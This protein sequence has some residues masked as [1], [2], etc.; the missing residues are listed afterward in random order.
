MSSAP[1]PLESPDAPVPPRIPPR[2]RYRA[3]WVLPIVAPPIRSGWVDVQDGRV[4]AVGAPG[5]EPDARVDDEIDLGR[6][7]LLPGLVNAH[8]HLELSWLWGRVPPAVSFTAWVGHLIALR[9]AEGDKPDA[10]TLVLTECEE[11]GT[12]LVGDI[13]NT[14]ASLPALAHSRLRAVIFHELLGFNVRDARQAIQA[15]RAVQQQAWTQLLELAARAAAP[16]SADGGGVGVGVGAGERSIDLRPADAASRLLVRTVPHAPY[17]VSPSLIREIANDA[18]ARGEVCSIHLGESP[19]EVQLLRDG[20]G[21]WREILQRVAE[22]DPDWRAPG[23][24]PADYLDA[25]GVLGPRLLVIHGVQLTDAELHLLARRKSTLV[26][27]PR[28][29]VW[30]GV[31]D[32]PIARFYASGVRVAIGTDSLASNSDLNI[33]NELAAMHHLAPGVPAGRL[34][35]SATRVGAEA[36]GVDDMGAIR[37]G[38]RARLITVD[39]PITPLDDIETYLVEGVDPGQIAWPIPE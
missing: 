9:R 4:R 33:F 14:L 8:T 36:L 26:T 28:S 34:L 2:V 29:N 21:P 30:V 5:E 38:D 31:G 32:P 1:H 19:E 12:A 35:A 39:L 24:G 25:L 13:A 3:A 7:A 23:C 6:V 22:W 37:P 15:A 27:C 16:A 11:A 17:S 20:R 10:M 18:E